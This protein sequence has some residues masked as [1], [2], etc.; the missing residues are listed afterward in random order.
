[1][2]SWIK[3]TTCLIKPRELDLCLMQTDE[4]VVYDGGFVAFENLL[5][6]GE[7]LGRHAKD[8]VFLRFDPRD[9][10]MLLVYSRHDGREKFIARAYAVGLEADQLSLE[11][12]KHS[13]KKL[14]KAGKQINN[15]AI[16][17][18]TI[19]RRK[20]FASK[21]N[22]TRKIVAMLRKQRQI[23]FHSVMRRISTSVCRSHPWRSNLVQL[24][25][26]SL[27]QNH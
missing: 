20:L 14:K 3:D 12:V 8:P 2:G 1:M 23:P 26:Q 19:R 15:V 7:N 27:Y 17:E 9:I 16:R 13:V 5:Y 18:E 10:T 4:R 24:M 6:K 11:E 25:Y 22:V 21:Q